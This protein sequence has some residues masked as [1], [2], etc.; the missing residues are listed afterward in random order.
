MQ[1]KK[2]YEGEECIHLCERQLLSTVD[3]DLHGR[4][5][6]SKQQ[7]DPAVIDRLPASA[8]SSALWFWRFGK[9][10]MKQ[11]PPISSEPNII[12]V[13]PAPMLLARWNAG[14]LRITGFPKN[15]P[16]PL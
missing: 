4:K 1:I 12:R 9:S 5:F 15:R 2:L 14:S 3:G 6:D 13:A 8:F 16:G 10:A 7:T 11:G